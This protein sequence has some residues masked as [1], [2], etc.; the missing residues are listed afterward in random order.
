MM[1]ECIDY[2]KSYVCSTVLKIID[3]T[4]GACQICVITIAIIKQ[5]QSAGGK[6]LF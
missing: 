6:S 2:Q 5:S 1:T 3:R 4:G